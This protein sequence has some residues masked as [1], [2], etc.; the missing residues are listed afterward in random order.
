[1]NDIRYYQ[2][3]SSWGMQDPCHPLMFCGTTQGPSKTTSSRQ[4]KKKQVAGGLLKAAVMLVALR[5]GAR[6]FTHNHVSDPR[7][8]L[9]TKCT[10]S[11]IAGSEP[12]SMWHCKV[13]LQPSWAHAKYY[14][15]GPTPSA[16]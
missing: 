13:I 8:P 12:H 1:M 2:M 4:R 6:H 15:F 3:I 14:R 11:R 7:A 5:N 10:I 9:P 16:T